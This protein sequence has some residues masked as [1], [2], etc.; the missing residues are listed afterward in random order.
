MSSFDVQEMSDEARRR[1]FTAL[2]RVYA[3]SGSVDP[4]ID[5]G[6]LTADEVAKTVAAMMRSADVTS[7]ELASLFNV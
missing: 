5:E 1:L 2:V 3:E 6:V 4:P 7:F